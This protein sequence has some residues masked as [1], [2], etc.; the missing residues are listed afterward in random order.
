MAFYINRGQVW[1][2][3]FQNED[4]ARAF[5]YLSNTTGHVLIEQ[6]DPSDLARYS[7]EDFHDG[8]KPKIK[9]PSSSLPQYGWHILEPG[10]L[11]YGKF[12]MTQS[13]LDELKRIGVKEKSMKTKAVIAV[14]LHRTLMNGPGPNFD[15]PPIEGAREAMQKLADAGH[16]IAVWTVGDTEGARNWLTENN[17][18]HDWVNWSPLTPED[19]DSGKIRADAYVDDKAVLFDGDWYK[20]ADDVLDQLQRQGRKS[21]RIKSLGDNPVVTKSA[22]TD[23]EYRATK[24]VNELTIA[25]GRTACAKFGQPE[26]KWNSDGI[27]GTVTVAVEPKGFQFDFLSQLASK[28]KAGWDG[29]Q[30]SFPFKMSVTGKSKSITEIDCPNCAG[31]E[32]TQC[33]GTGKIQVV[34]DKKVKSDT[35]STIVQA[36]REVGDWAEDHEGRMSGYGNIYLQN[37]LEPGEGYSIW[38]VGGDDDTKEFYKEC[39]AKLEAIPN[40][41]S[42]QYEAEEF[43]PD[44][45]KWEQ[46]YPEDK[47]E[48]S[49]GRTKAIS[50]PGYD[51]VDENYPSTW[52]IE[53]WEEPDGD[54]HSL[55]LEFWTDR[56]SHYAEFSGDLTG[57]PKNIQ[58][59]ILS[60][61]MGG[62]LDK[63]YW[64]GSPQYLRRENINKL[65]SK[66]LQNKD[67]LANLLATRKFNIFHDMILT[68]A[69]ELSI[70]LTKSPDLYSSIKSPMTALAN[71]TDE[72]R[73]RY[74]K[75]QVNDLYHYIRRVKSKAESHSHMSI[76]KTI[77]SIKWDS[78]D[79]KSR[80][81]MNM[82]GGTVYIND[83]HIDSL[84]YRT[85]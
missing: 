31:S 33:G 20:T 48:K 5:E 6:V 42:T 4:A 47:E 83:G 19:T 85:M 63:W 74:Y 76:N 61:P 24:L 14:D 12:R 79:G 73:K 56:S 10:I 70:D 45:G 3:P 23:A 75:E 60:K 37:P 80:S 44:D 36:I 8:R 72:D 34:D 84:L 59:A 55:K 32:C 52:K 57:V 58:D 2:G 18:Y 62:Q 50:I 9:P 41:D 82:R 11:I 81:G 43:P 15:K 67:T 77:W 26:I 49:K 25:A 68:W 65:A 21:L 7:P 16:D 53:T 1:I 78:E 46:V 29:K 69:D 27:S 38:Y 22:A 71:A 30:F 28:H 13:G 35:R 39:K 17:I 51:V 54:T 64:E 66:I 40:V